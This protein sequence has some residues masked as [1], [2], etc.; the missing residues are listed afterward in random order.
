MAGN[1][2]DTMI[3]ISLSFLTVV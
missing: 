3:K 1:K 2:I